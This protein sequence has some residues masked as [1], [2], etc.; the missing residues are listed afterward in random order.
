MSPGRV[1]V[2]GGGIAGLGSAALLARDG[3]SVDLVERHA[4]VG[5]RAGRWSKDGFTF[6][7]GPSWYLMPEVFDHFFGLFGTSAAEQLD[8]AQLDPAYRVF[9]EGDAEPLEI[10]ADRAANLAAFGER[11]AGADTALDSYLESAREVYDLAVRRFLYST[12]A[13]KKGLLAPDV[14]RRTPRLAGLLTRSLESHVAA[15]F[16]DHRLRQVLGYP[17]VFLGTAPDRAPSLYHLMSA[18]DLEDG[19]LYPRGGFTT[20][21]DAVAR[22]A[23]TSGVRIV[24]STTATAVEVDRTGRRPRVSGVT[25]R[26]SDGA[27]RTIPADLVVGAADLHHV[28]T[29]LVPEDLQTYPEDWWASRDPGPGAVLACLGVRGQL[30]ELAHHSLFFTRDWARNF[31]DIFDRPTRIPEPASAY[32]CKPSATDP[33]VAPPGDE[34]LFVLVPV[35]A[36]PSIGCGGVDGEGDPQVEKIADAALAQVAAWAGVPDLAQR[37]V[38][39]RTIG[40]GDF[41]RDL[42]AW[43]GGALGPAH[44]LRQSAFFRAGNASRKISGLLYAGAGTIP[45]I[46]L[47]MCLISA[48]LV[49]KRVR[50]DRSTQPLAEEG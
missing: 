11:E 47:P 4:E 35:P 46:G 41:A 26:D 8:L 22:M 29:Q 31:G 16:T 25:V 3:W 48:E 36:D 33:S 39:R 17:A 19:V 37:V 34:N 20:L 42:S 23:T 38:V 30:P 7:T 27:V 1:V 40:P 24:T 50:G 18:M 49:L 2:V 21:I 32:V 28:E 9:F 15:R 5:G 10:R 6:D 44:V 43:S 45:G 13:S 12:F 14:V